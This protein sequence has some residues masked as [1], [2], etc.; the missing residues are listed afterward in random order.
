MEVISEEAL[1][2]GGGTYL[3][4]TVYFLFYIMYKEFL[5]NKINIAS[6]NIILYFIL[7]DF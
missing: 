1:N 3:K 4:K 2:T 6:N 7:R 5:E